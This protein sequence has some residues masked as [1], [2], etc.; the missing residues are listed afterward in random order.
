MMDFSYVDE[1]L[2]AIRARIDAARARSDGR[3]VTL[4]AAVKYTDTE[5]IN[6]LHP[7]W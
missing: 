5:H 6:Y 3:E 2:A 1:N 7:P 4:L